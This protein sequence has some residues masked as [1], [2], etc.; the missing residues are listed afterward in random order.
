MRRGESVNASGVPTGRYRGLSMHPT[1]GFQ[2]IPPSTPIDDLPGSSAASDAP[3]L[4]QIVAPTVASRS[5]ASGDQGPCLFFGPRGERCSRRAV[6]NGFCSLHQPGAA[7]SAATATSQTAR[8]GK[9]IG[10]V[11]ALLG[12]LGPMLE[13]IIREILRWIHSH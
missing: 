6:R 8:W 9:I 10:A 7:R 1:E 5:A 4:P 2:L 13:N 3:E 11:I 12:F